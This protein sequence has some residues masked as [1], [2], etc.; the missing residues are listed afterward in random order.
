LR[1]AALRQLE[2]LRT[3][4]LELGRE[5]V[6]AYLPEMAVLDVLVPRL[7]KFGRFM[8]FP[9]ELRLTDAKT[10]KEN[11]RHN[12]DGDQWRTLKMKINDWLQKN[13]NKILERIVDEGRSYLGPEMNTPF[14]ITSWITLLEVAE[15]GFD[16]NSIKIQDAIMQFSLQILKEANPNYFLAEKARGN[17][18]ANI[19]LN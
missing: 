15:A 10:Q 6:I 3:K 16:V 5:K 2:T 9:S 7:A 4:L 8:P 12:L 17:V 14:D 13:R 11:Q 1:R 18:F 19:D